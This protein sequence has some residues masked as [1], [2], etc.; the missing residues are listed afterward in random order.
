MSGNSGFSVAYKY[1]A[2]GEE[3]DGGMIFWEDHSGSFFKPYFGPRDVKKSDLTKIENNTLFFVFPEQEIEIQ[4][5]KDKID[6]TCGFSR[7]GSC[8]RIELDNWEK[9][10]IKEWMSICYGINDSV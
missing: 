3:T 5:S 4:I 7:D 1:H 6:C 2:N 8:H 10:R 9:I